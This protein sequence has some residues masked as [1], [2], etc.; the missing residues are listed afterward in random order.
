[1]E[2]LFEIIK[3]YGIP[4]ADKVVLMN[5]YKHLEFFSKDKDPFVNDFARKQLKK[6]TYKRINKKL[7]KLGWQGE[8]D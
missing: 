2:N 7:K 3:L 6:Q 1:M 8:Q 5:Q 4:F